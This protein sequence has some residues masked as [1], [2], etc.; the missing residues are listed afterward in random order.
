MAV[1]TRAYTMETVSA[2]GQA[3]LQNQIAVAP[4]G[5]TVGVVT[6][7]DNKK[8]GTCTPLQRGPMSVPVYDLC[9]AE[10]ADGGK[11]A[12]TTVSSE[13]YIAFTGVGLAYS[14]AGEAAV[15]YTGNARG[16][17][18][19]Q[20][21]CGASNLLMRSGKAGQFG[22]PRTLAT[23]SQGT[24]VPD[25][26]KNC[27][28]DVCN[29][30]DAVGYWPAVA[31]SP[32][33]SQPAVIYRDLHFGFAADDFASSDVE[34]AAGPGFSILTVDVARGGGTFGH[35]A[36]RKN[37]QAVV[38]HYNGERE[39]STDGIWVN[40]DTGGGVWAA[41]RV[42]AVVTEGGLGFAISKQGLH[43]LAYYD[44]GS[45]RLSYVESNDGQSWSTPVDIDTDG[46]TGQFPALAFN[47]SGEPC[48]AYYRC[49]DYDPTNRSCDQDRDGLM[50][51]R[52]SG[53]TWAVE[54]VS[55]QAGVLDGT[56]PALAFVAGKAVI[57]F[58][59]SAFDPG[60]G[61]THNELDVA[62]E[63]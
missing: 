49:R 27:I 25:Q 17:A 14:P 1:G 41:A 36:F 50:L 38:V 56:Y 5:S 15:A 33:T 53:T 54:S 23:S 44:S 35:L 26:Q 19:A 9:F 59:K 45:P 20:Q 6:I 16:V 12:T 42:S 21:R 40:Q 7:A 11:F 31:F 58:Q 61:K 18:E 34:Y 57:A 48:V 28:Q 22:A 46:I 2:C 52:R 10:S 43:A 3:G 8:T 63:Q 4:D 37:G 32:T 51:A 13:A 62:R 29:S 60:T 30:G 39:K 55:A 24:P 47:D